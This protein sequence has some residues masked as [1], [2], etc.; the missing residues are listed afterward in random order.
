[1][2][3]YV[4]ERFQRAGFL[5]V[6]DEE[7]GFNAANAQDGAIAVRVYETV[8]QAVM[9]RV[10]ESDGFDTWDEKEKVVENATEVE[11]KK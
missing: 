1:M 8:G 3:T 2:S 4:K 6:I 10:M 9:A 5:L 11:E 7:G